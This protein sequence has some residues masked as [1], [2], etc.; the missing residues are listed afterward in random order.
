MSFVGGIQIIFFSMLTFLIGSQ[1]GPNKMAA[2]NFLWLHFLNN[3]SS[4][5]SFFFF[6]W[7]QCSV[8]VSTLLLFVLAQIFERIFLPWNP[9]ER[10]TAHALFYHL[11]FSPI[12]LLMNQIPFIHFEFMLSK[13]A[14][15]ARS[16]YTRKKRLQI[17]HNPCFFHARWFESYWS[18]PLWKWSFSACCV[19]FYRKSHAE[20]LVLRLVVSLCFILFLLPDDYLTS[21]SYD[22]T[23]KVIT[24]N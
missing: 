9:T 15:T 14:E 22:A 1:G 3:G 18:I 12:H 17:S 13:R 19:Q 21:T 7:D 8:L 6:F 4:I 10:L 23:I 24:G 5:Q 11:S 16:K 20:Y 2:A